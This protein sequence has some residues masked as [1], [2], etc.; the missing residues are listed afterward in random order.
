MERHSRWI[1][2]TRGDGQV[3][4]FPTGTSG[5]T[6]AVIP[7]GAE[8]EPKEL[9]TEEALAAAAQPLGVG[10]GAGEGEGPG[11]K[12]GAPPMGGHTISLRFN[13]ASMG[14]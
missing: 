13:S 4:S 7:E 5:A 2:G 11:A 14:Q 8:E 1:T 12:D 9:D 10:A 6:T 3:L